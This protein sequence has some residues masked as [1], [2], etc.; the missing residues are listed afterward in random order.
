MAPA[1]SDDLKTLETREMVLTVK[2][3]EK[4]VTLN[5]SMFTVVLGLMVVVLV[6][7]AVTLGV[8][9]GVVV[10]D[11]KTPGSPVTVSID[12]NGG[13]GGTGGV[14]GSGGAGTASTA[15]AASTPAASTPSKST[16]A[17]ST[18]ATKPGDD[19][20]PC[21]EKKPYDANAPGDGYFNN[22]KCMEDGVM[23]ALE[24]SGTNVTLGYKGEIDTTGRSPIT[25][26]YKEAGLCPVNVHWHLGAEHLSTGQYDEG[27]KGPAHRRRMRSMLAESVRQGFQ[28]HFYNKDDAKFTKPY[29]WK[30]CK[31]ME[32]GQTYEIHWPHSAAGMCGSDWQMQTPFYDGVFCKD[33]IISLSPLNTFQKI[34]VQ[35]QVF[36][37]VN[38]ERYHY[39]NLIE[40]MIVHPGTEHGQD[41]AKYTGSTTGTS[42]SNE[43]CSRYTPITWQ[44]DRKCHM[45]S[46]SSFDKLCKDM[47]AQKDD[48]SDDLHAH[49]A[50]ELVASQFAADNHQRIM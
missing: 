1:N 24:Q 7:C 5:R 21:H 12:S 6:I 15:S 8:V 18:P 42:R 44:V 39:D 20:N 19:A 2:D 25:T 33:G 45:V 38:D 32:V 47:K 11:N 30:Y 27:G 28:C 26:T 43:I 35:A 16:P 49:G 29:E 3:E 14:G 46:A 37:I 31:D 34:G 10:N 48:M 40:G 4:T 9:V 36:T 13:V 50:R 22:V 23:Q 17:A 41:I